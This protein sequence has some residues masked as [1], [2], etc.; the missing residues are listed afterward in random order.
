MNSHD[1]SRMPSLVEFGSD[2]S[3]PAVEVSD[4]GIDDLGSDK[5]QELSAKNRKAVIRNE[6]RKVVR[7]HGSNGITVSEVSE[8]TGLSDSAV[9]SHLDTLCRLREVYRQKRNK[10]LYL[11]YPNGKPIHSVG[12]ERVDDGSETILELKLAKGRD[13][14][15]FVHVLEKRFSLMEGET[16]EGAVMFPVNMFERFIEKGGK[17]VSEVKP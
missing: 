2:I 7:K 12:T 4:F 5:L 6:I 8:I 1:E 11:Y 13:D 10:R 9:R 3:D 14:Q 17:L 16:T 15:Y